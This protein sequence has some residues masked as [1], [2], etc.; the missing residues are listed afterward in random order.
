MKSSALPM[1]SAPVLCMLLSMGFTGVSQAARPAFVSQQT[2]AIEGIGDYTSMQ[3]DQMGRTHVAYFDQ[4]RDALVYAFQTQNG[5]RTELVDSDGMVGWYASLA[6]DS[7]GDA[8]VAYYDATRGVLKYA[9]RA[10]GV[11]SAQVVDAS[12]E[13]VGHYCSLALD[14]NDQPAISY[15][16]GTNLSLRFAARV[17]GSW[18]SEVVDGA[19]NA[20][21]AEEQILQARQG[22][23][24]PA[25]S[26]EVP[27]V[28]HYTSLAIGRD[29]TAHISYQD[30]TRADLK[31]AVKRNGE[32]VTETVDN[33]GDVGEHTSLA[34]DAEGE[35]HISYYD[36]QS[37]AL[38]YAELKGGEWSKSAIDAT[39]DVGAYSSLE[40]DAEGRPHVSYMDAEAGALKYAHEQDGVWMMEILDASGATGRNTSL[41]LDRS[42]APVIA[43]T[44]RGGKG[45]FRV[46][47][48]SVQFGGRPSGQS[49]SVAT[50][51]SLSA[52]PL[53]YKGGELN[54][55]FVIPSR[56]G[57]AEVAL[58]DL[59]GRRVRT[60]QKGTMEAG[61]QVLTWNGRDDAGR[62]VPNGVYFLTTRMG[63][64]ESR[65]K[66]VVLR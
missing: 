2:S 62:T 20:A 57:Q 15:Y 18:Q 37:G 21:A 14:A 34:I 54:V 31:Y 45:S 6:L 4:A 8:H 23:K 12:V 49:G 64:Q 24:A 27:N 25:A 42:G 39:G 5:W 53:P 30:I 51:R 43:Y 41:S 10:G 32:W 35:P 55:S 1:F 47:S 56:G 59:A 63:E 7:R 44:A 60:L 16:D 9:T 33:I 17:D 22:S 11:W 48:A 36:L 52:W 66:L 50:T 46:V 3:L 40:L 13:G 38:K 26:E 58:L 29:G 19:Q 28:G 65:L 61:R